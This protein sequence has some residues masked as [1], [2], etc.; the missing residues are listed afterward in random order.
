MMSNFPLYN[1][2]DEDFENL[3]ILICNKILGNATIPFSKGKDGG[4][5]GRFHG[6][7]NSFPSIES[8]WNGKIIIQAKHT[9]K[10]NSSCS[11]SD[12]KTIIRKDIIPSIGKL[13]VRK[14]IDFYLLFTNRKLTG[15][16]DAEIENQIKSQTQI[17]NVVIANEKIQSLLQEYPEIVKTANLNIL[18]RPF[19]FDESDIKEI[20]SCTYEILKKQDKTKCKTNFSYPGLEHKNKLNN[21]SNNYFEDSIKKEFD[22]FQRIEDFLSSPINEDL[23]DMYDDTISELNAKIAL[24][25]DAYDGFQYIIEKIYDYIV[26]YNNNELSKKKRLVRTFLSYMYCNC[27]IG[28]KE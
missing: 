23:K 16:R 11:D 15:L 26:L 3:T 7:A 18:L 8:P 12:F 25:R 2:N 19:E 1:L 5:D 22:Y 28:K 4:K 17:T 20:I 6:R 14:E 24:E 21:I 9:T 13:I 10:V 27:D